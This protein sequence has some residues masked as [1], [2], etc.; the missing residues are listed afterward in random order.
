MLLFCPSSSSLFFSL[1]DNLDDGE[2][3]SAHL[4]LVDSTRMETVDQRVVTAARATK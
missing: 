1:V 3:T 4:D 2:F